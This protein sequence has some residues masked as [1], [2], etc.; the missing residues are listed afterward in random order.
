MGKWAVLL[1]FSLVAT[2]LIS[3]M[4]RK[5]TDAFAPISESSSA[6]AS[7]SAPSAT[8]AGTDAPADH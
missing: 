8:D 6:P 5:R 3:T 7:T 2:G 4:G 1:T